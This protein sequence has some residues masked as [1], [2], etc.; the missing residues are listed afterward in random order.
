MKGL[1]TLSLVALGLLALHLSSCDSTPGTPA[2]FDPEELALV[3]LEPADGES[4]VPRNRVVRMF[5]N[6]QVLPESVD[7]QSILVRIGGTFQTRPEGAFLTTGDTVEFDP[8]VAANGGRNALGFP[9][10]EQVLVEI[11]LKE[12]NDGVPSEQFLQNIEGNPIGIASGDNIITFVTGAGWI[13]PVPGPPG[14]LGLDFTPGPNNIGQVP[15]NAA[16]TIIFSEPIDP[17]TFTLGKNIF[18]TNNTS[19]APPTLFQQ[20]IPSLVFFDGSLT[21]Y[22]VQPVFGFG[23]GPF[24]VLVNFI[25]PDAPSTFNPN[26]LP[27]DL[28]ANKVQN[29]TFFGQFETQFDPNAQTFSLLKEDFLTTAKRNQAFTDALWGNDP[30]F[31]FA[32]VG[33]PITKRNQQ[34]N[35]VAFTTVSGG[36]TVIDNPPLGGAIGEEDYCPTQNPLVGSDSIINVGNPPASSGRRQM[37]LYRQAELGARGTVVRIAWGPDSDATFAATYPGVIMRLGHKQAGTDLAN[38]GMFEQFDVDGFVTLVN[39]KD[40]T[41]P[42]AF[43]VNGGGTNDGYLDWPQLDIFFDFD[44]QNDLLLDVEAGEGNTYQTFRTFLALDQIF[45]VCT[46]F[47]Y[48]GCSLTNNS[49]GQRQMD[50]T[51]GGDAADP[52][53]IPATVA[54]PAPFVHVMEFELAKLRSDARSLYYNA[55]IPDPDFLSPII[56]PLV[57]SGGATIEVTWSG[58]FDGIVEDVPFT[59]NIHAI[60][61]HRYIRWNAVMRSNLFTSGR[62][63]I[64][65]LEMPFL[66][67]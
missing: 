10:G 31:P 41:V 53:P 48:A 40:Y 11:R 63:R 56:S 59:P 7:D 66:I 33:Q 30:E 13:D 39:Q 43:D 20:D 67:P 24:K 12:P 32:L 19:T 64:D 62:P 52:G 45:G 15:P 25:D 4:S 65:I 16:V 29:F 46:C 34:C 55:G 37:N 28:G 23:Q 26:G 50:S 22:T 2:S 14:V 36:T 18:L 42:Q 54:N 17:G 6:T 61:N 9:A 38:A 35:I 60:D 57:Q 49:I 44:G 3:R 47:N 27:A 8:T 21:R 51:Y 5:F 1:S 58:S